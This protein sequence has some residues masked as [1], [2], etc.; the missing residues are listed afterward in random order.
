VPCTLM[1]E[2]AGSG[3]ASGR[4]RRCDDGRPKKTVA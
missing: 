4:R 2:P 3:P 1:P